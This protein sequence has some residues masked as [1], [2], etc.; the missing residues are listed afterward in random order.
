MASSL[1]L[2]EAILKLFCYYKFY[3]ESFAVNEG[4]RAQR[5]MHSDMTSD[6]ATNRS[7]VFLR[8]RKWHAGKTNML[9][10]WRRTE[11][12]RCTAACDATPV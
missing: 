1:S 12:A 8:V 6:Y 4:H 3:V 7:S 5:L 10:F 2:K 9:D 11:E